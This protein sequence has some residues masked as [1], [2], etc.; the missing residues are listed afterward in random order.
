MR[1]FIQWRDILDFQIII[2]S[3]R[4]DDSLRISG[5]LIWQHFPALGGGGLR[6]I[7]VQREA[8]AIVYNKIAQKPF[9][10][11]NKKE[12]AYV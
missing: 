2:K 3:K 11:C 5:A 4:L 1:F 10:K 12:I 9:Q 6:L 7:T 8:Y